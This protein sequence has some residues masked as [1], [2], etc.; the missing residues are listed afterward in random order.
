MIECTAKQTKKNLQNMQV[1]KGE[2][3]RN[4]AFIPM[5]SNVQSGVQ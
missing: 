2:I 1:S 5:I 3:T 4:L